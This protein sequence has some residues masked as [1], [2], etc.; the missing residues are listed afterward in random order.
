LPKFDTHREGS[1]KFIPTEYTDEVIDETT[2]AA[3]IMATNLA[4]TRLCREATS[5]AIPTNTVARSQFKQRGAYRL[6][7]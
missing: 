1:S 3:S 2:A 5:Y 6:V 4:I 7:Q